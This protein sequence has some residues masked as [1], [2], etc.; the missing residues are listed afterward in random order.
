[1]KY[2]AVEKHPGDADDV[3]LVEYH[4]TKTGASVVLNIGPVSLFYE[5]SL[6]RCVSRGWPKAHF[7]RGDLEPDQGAAEKEWTDI[8]R[9]AFV[10]AT[11]ILFHALKIERIR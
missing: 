11:T 4:D 3:H 6:H 9:E 10:D 8:D 2:R 7:E 5:D 1:M